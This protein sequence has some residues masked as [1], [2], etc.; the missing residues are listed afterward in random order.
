MYFSD[1]FSLGGLKNIFQNQA[2]QVL[3]FFIVCL[4]IWN[5]SLYAAVFYNVSQLFIMI[6]Y[7]LHL[8][9]VTML[10]NTDLEHRLYCLIFSIVW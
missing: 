5:I 6:Q 2:N 4:F 7:Y 9:V 1:G 8:C 3:I 10:L